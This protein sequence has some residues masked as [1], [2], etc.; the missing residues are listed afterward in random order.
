MA[1]PRLSLKRLIEISAVRF[2]SVAVLTLL[3]VFLLLSEALAQ[4]P[5]EAAFVRGHFSDGSGIW[6]ADDFGWFYYDM[7]NAQGGEQLKIDMQGRLAEKGRIVYSS[8]VWSKQFEFEPWGSYQS[9]AFFGKPYL[10]GYPE[11]NFTEEVSSLGK[12]ELREMLLDTRDTYTLTPNSS[13]PLKNGYI[14]AVNEISKG[15]DV[16]EFVL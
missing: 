10:A 1:F 9:V 14:L 3:A 7:D 2:G 15:N 13:L 11:S 12:G 6:R 16:V 4:E 8:S 5:V